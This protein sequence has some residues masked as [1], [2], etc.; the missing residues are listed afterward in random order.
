MK[1]CVKRR[2]PRLRSIKQPST[3]EL[4]VFRHHHVDHQQYDAAGDAKC[5]DIAISRHAQLVNQRQDEQ[6]HAHDQRVN[7]GPG[8]EELIPANRDFR[9]RRQA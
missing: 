1:A 3:D 8:E 9:A 7:G 4:G 6:G 5:V 2:M